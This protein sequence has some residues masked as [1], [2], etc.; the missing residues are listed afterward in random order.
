MFR[1]ALFVCPNAV[2][3]LM[4]TPRRGYPTPTI[5]I[6]VRAGTDGHDAGSVGAH[7]LLP[8]PPGFRLP[9]D[10]DLAGEADARLTSRAAPASVA[11]AQRGQHCES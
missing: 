10:D 3:T 8:A 5:I 2:P 11:S 6:P 9:S 7:R 4:K 1:Q